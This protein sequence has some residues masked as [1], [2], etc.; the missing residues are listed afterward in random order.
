MRE[1]ESLNQCLLGKEESC[2]QKIKTRLIHRTQ[3]L[4][5]NEL[6]I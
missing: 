5:P 2:I 1:A 6:K 3:K 4:T